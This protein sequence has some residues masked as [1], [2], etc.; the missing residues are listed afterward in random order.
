M[1]AELTAEAEGTADASLDHAGITLEATGV[2]FYFGA[3]ESPYGSNG[4][5]LI[6]PLKLPIGQ[7]LKLSSGEDTRAMPITLALTRGASSTPGAIGAVYYV[8][9][10]N[11]DVHAHPA[12]LTAEVAIPDEQFDELLGL[13]RLGRFPSP[14]PASVT[15][16][17]DGRS[18]C[19]L[20]SATTGARPRTR[21]QHSACARVIFIRFSGHVARH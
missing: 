4:P 9:K 13:A 2:R 17:R 1:A 7:S 14:P 12:H 18:E 15:D 21:A 16:L 11:D 10:Y 6:Y 8:E 20:T 3:G 5:R 19:H